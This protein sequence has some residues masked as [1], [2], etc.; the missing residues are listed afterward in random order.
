MAAA[1]G[2]MERTHGRGRL[3]DREEDVAVMKQTIR[4]EPITLSWTKWHDWT[5][6]RRRSNSPGGVVITTA[7]GVYQVRCV[8]SSEPIYIGCTKRLWRRLK[9][10]LRGKHKPGFK[11]LRS[12]RPSTLQV[13]W[14]ETKRP[15]CIEEELLDRFVREY[16]RRPRYNSFHR[17]TRDATS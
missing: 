16:K 7:S 17:A 14:A 10:L 9:V 6:L 5:T 13:R 1:A 3:P 2:E 15:A 8:K 12:H 11:I 4:I